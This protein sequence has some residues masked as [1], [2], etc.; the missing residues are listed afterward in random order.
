ML[1][2]NVSLFITIAIGLLGQSC[3]AE[4]PVATSIKRKYAE[5][6]QPALPTP[7]P[8]SSEPSTTGDSDVLA[9]GASLY[10]EKKCEDCHGALESSAKKGANASRI[11]A[12]ENVPKH[13]EVPTW[14][15]PEEIDAIAAALAD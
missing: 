3:A 7:P 14:P 1:S 6:G 11:A 15:T 2:K 10:V 8:K 5:G 13:A 12:S 4:E 9:L